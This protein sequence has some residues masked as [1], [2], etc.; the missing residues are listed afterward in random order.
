MQNKLS[1]NLSQENITLL[2]QIF[3]CG[4]TNVLHQEMENYKTYLYIFFFGNNYLGNS[5]K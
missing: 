5:G 1:Q 3:C 4:L 2:P